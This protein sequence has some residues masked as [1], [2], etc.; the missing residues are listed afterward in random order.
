MFHPWRRIE[1]EPAVL[2]S[3]I[4]AIA[5]MSIGNLLFMNVYCEKIIGTASTSWFY[6]LKEA[7]Y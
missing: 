4:L 5:L 7:I 6:T 2:N 1:Y 3:P